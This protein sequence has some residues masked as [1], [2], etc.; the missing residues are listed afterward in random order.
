RDIILESPWH[1]RPA[2]MHHADRAIDVLD[3][4]DDDAKA[5][6]VRQLLKADRL[7]FHLA[8][9]RVGLLFAAPDLRANLLRT[10]RAGQFGFDLLDQVP[11]LV[12]NGDEPRFD[13]AV[14]IGRQLAEG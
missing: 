12:L 13:R 5:V 1:D 9:D 2:L 4:A 11:V 10:E 6:D 8:P 7:A 3:V 14:G